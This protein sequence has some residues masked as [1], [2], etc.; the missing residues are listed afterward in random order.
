[1]EGLYQTNF[2]LHRQTDFYRGKVRDIYY[3][4]KELGVV[5]TDRISAFDV[6]MPVPIPHKGQIL[7][8]IAWYN[9][10]ETSDI[11]KNWTISKPHPNVTIG[12]KAN[13][14]PLEMVVRGFLAGHAWRVYKEGGRSLCG[15]R[16]PEGLKQ[17]EEFPS[18]IITPS[19]KAQEGHDEDISH[20]DIL[21]QGLVTETEWE[22]LSTTALALFARGQQLARKKGLILV[23]TKYEFGK[24]EEGEIILIDEVHTPDSS[25]YF[26]LEGYEDRLDQGKPQ[27]QLSKEFIREWLMEQGFP[28]K[29]EEIPNFSSTQV[30]IFSQR[31]IELYNA[32][33]PKPF[34]AEPYGNRQEDIRS[35]LSDIFED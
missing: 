13:P 15:N 10:K 23:D 26:Y 1:M 19:T 6:V 28:Y 22:K 25:R 2:Q 30:K 5:T 35:V 32:L 9:L 3:F 14:I 12:K 24:T 16:L 7:N 20:Q 29:T 31:Y 18:P 27:Q 34:Q 8:E 4:G 33:M 21:A 11:I 17:N